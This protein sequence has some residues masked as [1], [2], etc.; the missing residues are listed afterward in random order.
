MN[1]SNFFLVQGRAFLETFP[2]VAL[3][4]VIDCGKKKSGQKA[5]IY[6]ASGGIGTFAVQIARHFAI[7]VT[8]VCSGKYRSGLYTTMLKYCFHIFCK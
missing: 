7:E 2:I 5:L 8:V 1:A 4:A 3:R 6:G